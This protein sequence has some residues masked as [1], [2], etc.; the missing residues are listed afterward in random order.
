MTDYT[1]LATVKARLG[2]DTTEYD[3]VLPSYITTASRAVDRWCKRH[4]NGFVGATE[5]RIFDVPDTLGGAILFVRDTGSFGGGGVMGIPAYNVAI[6]DL[7]PLLS[8][9]TTTPAIVVQTDDDGDGTYETTWA[10]TGAPPDFDLEPLNALLDGLPY[11][12]IRTRIGGTKAFPVGQ[13]RLSVTALWGEQ[14]ATPDLIREATI[15]VAHRWFTRRLNAYGMTGATT[16][17]TLTL[18]PARIPPADPDVMA[19]L[20]DAG[21]VDHWFAV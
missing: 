21:Y 16:N 13:R 4:D 10:G 1:D 5:T 11:R 15:L 12:R 17:A 6:I 2:I 20:A 9:A 14:A 18:P 8:D 3:A 19:M 7:D